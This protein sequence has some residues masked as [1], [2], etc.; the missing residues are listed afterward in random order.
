MFLQKKRTR[1]LFLY[2]L[3]VSGLGILSGCSDMNSPLQSTQSGG[4][5]NQ[6]AAN[7]AAVSIKKANVKKILGGGRM[8]GDYGGFIHSAD[9]NMKI[10]ATIKQL[11]KLHVNTYFYKIHHSS[12]AW[13]NL[14]KKFMPA[15][16]K[17]GINVFVYLSCPAAAI[18]DKDPNPF[19]T[20]YIH[21]AKAIAH[22]SLKYSHLKGWTIDDFTENLHIFT[23][24]YVKKMQEAAH[25]VNPDLLFAPIVYYYHASSKSFHRKYGPYLDGIIFPYVVFYDLQQ[26]PGQLDQITKIWPSKRVA[27]MIYASRHSNVLNPPPTS[28]V[29]KALQ[30]GLNY[31]KHGKLAG[32][33]TYKLTKD[34]RK[35]ICKNF[36]HHVL[37]FAVNW[38]IATK[39]GAYIEASQKVRLDPKARNY[40]ISFSQRDDR[41]YSSPRGYHIKQ[42]LVD[43]GVVWHKDV[44][45][46]ASDKNYKVSL[47]LTKYLKGKSSAKIAFRLY[48]KRAVSAYEV[49]VT[50]GKIR[51]YGFHVANN[52]CFDWTFKSIGS[53]VHQTHQCH[54]CNPHRQQK[55]FDAVKKLYSKW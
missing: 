8:L 24:S 53:K 27:L 50:F 13:R 51:G 4:I 52:G 43:G 15:A 16:Q 7:R 5:L 2:L 39:K 21:W 23:P 31:K 26:L 17:A 41:K 30:I 48:E 35:T 20:D 44:A 14:L 11:K 6:A 36:V 22:L 10:R 49:Q 46:D 28:Y 9:R 1:K 37:Q 55:M 45:K 38:Q 47:D 18:G 32:V 29:R 25:K 12:A 33:L 34:P 40:R 19:G 42:F 54:E 3:V